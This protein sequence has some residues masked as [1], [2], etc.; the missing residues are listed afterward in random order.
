MNKEEKNQMKMNKEEEKCLVMI[1]KK[2]NDK[3]SLFY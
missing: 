2:I 1:E 3:S